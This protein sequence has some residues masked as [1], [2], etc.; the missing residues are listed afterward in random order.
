LPNGGGITPASAWLWTLGL[1]QAAPGGFDLG[2]G[3]GAVGPG[4]ALAVW[5]TTLSRG[6][7]GV[8]VLA[9]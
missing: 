8:N 5:S 2:L 6:G 9:A 4:R 7:P 3:G 1:P